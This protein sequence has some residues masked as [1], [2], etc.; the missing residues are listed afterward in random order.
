MGF[1]SWASGMAMYGMLLAGAAS[2]EATA[3]DEAIPVHVG[4]GLFLAAI[5]PGVDVTVIFRGP[6][7]EVLE[8]QRFDDDWLNCS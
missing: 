5:P 4:N 2:I 3:G 1:T 6:Q 7:G 8:E